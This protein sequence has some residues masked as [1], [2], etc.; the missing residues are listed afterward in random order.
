[1]Y[2]PITRVVA[3]SLAAALTGAPAYS[4]DPVPSPETGFYESARAIR[5]EKQLQQSPFTTTDGKPVGTSY[6]GAV[7][8]GPPSEI[9][10]VSTFHSL[11]DQVKKLG[12]FF[13]PEIRDKLGKWGLNIGP[14]IPQGVDAVVKALT[15]YGANGVDGFTYK[16]ETIAAPAVGAGVILGL[17]WAG[18]AF[19]GGSSGAAPAAKKCG[20]FGC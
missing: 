1:M 19:K 15:D 5:L 20:P 11:D 7:L 3:G 13:T 17:A 14:Y 4:A 9:V 16:T 8:T 10:E 12:E 2:K 6:S 18:G